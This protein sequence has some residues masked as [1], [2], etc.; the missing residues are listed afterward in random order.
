[1]N[2]VID[3]TAERARREAMKKPGPAR[4]MGGGFELTVERLLAIYDAINR[5]Q[6]TGTTDETRSI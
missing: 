3:L 6:Q 5:R 1:M 2:N 4:P